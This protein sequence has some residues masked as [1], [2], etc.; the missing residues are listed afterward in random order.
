MLS[1]NC[2]SPAKEALQLGNSKIFTRIPI[3]ENAQEN[4][5]G[6]VKIQDLIT[7]QV[8]G[9]N[10]ITLKSIA[11]PIS[12]VR[13]DSNCLTVFSDFLKHR[14]HI[15]MIVDEFDSICGLITLEDLLESLIGV[16]IVDEGEKHTDM[17]KLARQ[18][19]F[20]RSLD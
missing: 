11:L 4:V 18:K 20:K 19:K 13:G 2:S 10:E 12:F 16:E 3:W 14:K 1:I 17:Q 5:V 15:A 6:Y 8:N 7:S 9:N